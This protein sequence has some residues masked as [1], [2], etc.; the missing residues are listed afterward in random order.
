MAH[1]PYIQTNNQ[2]DISYQ[3]QRFKLVGFPQ[4]R[5]DLNA[6]E[7]PFLTSGISDSEVFR[8]FLR[9]AGI[10]SLGGARHGDI[11]QNL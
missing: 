1:I 6:F 4:Q 5:S 11:F 3:H 2:I 9:D 8:A 7:S 10:R